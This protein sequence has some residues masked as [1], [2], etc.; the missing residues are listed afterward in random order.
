MRGLLRDVRREFGDFRVWYT[1][2]YQDTSMPTY[3]FHEHCEIYYQV[4]G[5]KCFFIGDR[6]YHLKKG[7]IALIDSNVIHRT[8]TYGERGCERVLLNISRSF[9][10]PADADMT[11]ARLYR[12]F[13]PNGLVLRLGGKEQTQVEFLLESMLTADSDDT[14]LQRAYLKTLVMQLLVLL[15]LYVRDQQ[16]HL[17]SYS[18][19]YSEMMSPIITYIN[20]HFMDP[21]SLP[22]T[23]ERF[24][25]STSSLT[26]AFKRVTGYTFTQYL[27][28][29]RVKE[30][31][32]LLVEEN[33][34]ITKVSESVGY[35]SINHF[36]RVFRRVSGCSA[37]QFKKAL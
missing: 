36:C 9:L 3:H 19:P 21:V 15:N 33:L 5:E 7:D 6:N 20:S 35:N 18:D 8:T 14:Q 24:H 28:L 1:G 30:A 22:S 23:A 10:S 11:R 4:S 12:C 31:K 16:L 37:L 27:S 17:V 26:R 29:V 13:R 2:S 34:S 25:V 32:R